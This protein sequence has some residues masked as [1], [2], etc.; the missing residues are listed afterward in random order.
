MLS[1]S[2]LHCHHYHHHASELWTSVSNVKLLSQELQAVV[3]RYAKEARTWRQKEENL[4]K[5]I[6]VSSCVS[7]IYDYIS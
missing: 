7:V 2:G 1:I 3:D 6:N 4:L 5:K